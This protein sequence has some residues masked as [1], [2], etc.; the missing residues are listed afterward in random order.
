MLSNEDVRGGSLWNYPGLGL[1]AAAAAV[2]ACY[3]PAAPL[4]SQR[5]AGRLRSSQGS[6]L[7][8]GSEAD[9]Y[10]WGFVTP[11]RPVPGPQTGKTLPIK[12]V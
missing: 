4:A 2:P 12:N 8:K 7:E 1:V 11:I 9:V 3:W 5:A 10:L 6:G